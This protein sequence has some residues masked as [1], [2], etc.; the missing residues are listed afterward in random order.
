[1]AILGWI[2]VLILFA[3]GGFIGW[4]IVKGLKKG[5]HTVEDWDTVRM[6]KKGLDQR[7]RQDAVRK[8]AAKEWLDE[9]GLG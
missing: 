4:L 8:R 2:G 1:V 3:I 5:L 7:A 9:N 6:T